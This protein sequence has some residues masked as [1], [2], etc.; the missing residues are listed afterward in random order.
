[1]CRCMQFKYHCFAKKTLLPGFQLC[2]DLIH[3]NKAV[4]II[5]ISHEKYTSNLNEWVFLQIQEADEYD[6]KLME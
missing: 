4:F 3:A 6:K 5:E 2:V 1:M